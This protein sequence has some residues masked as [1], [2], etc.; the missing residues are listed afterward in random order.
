MTFTVSGCQDYGNKFA[1]PGCLTGKCLRS[2]INHTETENALSMLT[3][4][5]VPAKQIIFGVPTYGRSFR[6][7]DKS[8]TGPNCL[9][10]GAYAVSDAEPGPCTQISGYISNAELNEIF[11]YAEAGE[12]MFAAKRWR[13]EE[14]DSDIMTY[15][16]QGNGPSDVEGGWGLEADN[17][18]C[19]SGSWPST[20]ENPESNTDSAPAQCRGKALMRILLKESVVSVD[21]YRRYPRTTVTR[22]ETRYNHGEVPST[23]S[24]LTE[25]APNPGYCVVEFTMRDEERLYEAL[26]RAT[27][28]EKTGS[29]GEKR[30]PSYTLAPLCHR[31]GACPDEG[32]CSQNFYMRKN[33][34]RQI[35]DKRT[36]AAMRTDTCDADEGDIFT[37]L[38]LPLFM[39][40][41]ASTI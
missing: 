40:Q 27:G 16:T 2:H 25:M 11:Q 36:Y 20:L 5:G 35:D 12:P 33:W 34:P 13:D 4:A 17:L 8:C 15:G 6:M 26:L 38:S 37:A 3:K 30:T 19:D 41:D 1:N 28:V 39:L 9:F 18:E 14:T 29:R 32:A 10:T 24:E 7:A 23:E 22:W 31:P 21:E